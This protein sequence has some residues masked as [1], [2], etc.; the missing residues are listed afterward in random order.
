MK[1]IVAVLFVATLSVFGS[2]VF[3]PGHAFACDTL[4]KVTVD[5]ITYDR[6]RSTLEPCAVVLPATAQ[7]IP[8]V[9]SKPGLV[10]PATI[11]PFSED[12]D[13]LGGTATPNGTSNSSTGV[14]ATPSSPGVSATPSSLGVASQI[15]TC[16]DPQD[17]GQLSEA[18][19]SFIG[20]IGNR[21]G[22]TA[23]NSVLDGLNRSGT[24]GRVV[25]DVF[26]HG[27]SEAITN[28]GQAGTQYAGNYV[29]GQIQG[30]FGDSQLGQAAG[31]IV[32]NAAGQIVQ[33]V[34]Q[35]VVTN[36]AGQF[37]VGQSGGI[38][39]AISGVL[40]GNGGSGVLS[41]VLGGSGVG[42][43]TGILS[44]PV[45]D[46][47]V[48]GAVQEV[49]GAVQTA[50]QNITNKSEEIR[51][52]TNSLDEQSK[53]RLRQEC[54]SKPA[55]AQLVN[56]Q[57]QQ[58]TETT[59]SNTAPLVVT[60]YTQLKRDAS[61]SAA[62]QFINNISG[63]NGTRLKQE[64]TAQETQRNDP[65]QPNC[66]DGNTNPIMRM[67]LTAIHDESCTY[68]GQ[69][70]DSIG[71]IDVARQ[72]AVNQTSEVVAQGGG[73]RSAGTCEG[74]PDDPFEKCQGPNDHW[75]TALPSSFANNQALN[76]VNAPQQRL[77]NT[78][79]TGEIIN[80]AFNSLLDE[81][82]ATI[83]DEINGGISGLFSRTG[84]SGSRNNS[85]GSGTSG[86]VTNTPDTNS[87]SYFDQLN[88]TTLTPEDHSDILSENIA[89]A[90][91]IESAYRSTMETMAAN[92]QVVSDIYSNIYSCYKTLSTGSPTSI[93]RD[94]ALNRATTAST[95]VSSVFTAQIV[96]LDAR[97]QTSLITAS[98]LTILANQASATTDTSDLAA[99]ASA[100][101]TLV[102]AHKTHTRADL[103]A[104]VNDMNADA[105][106]LQ[107][108]AD[109][110]AT[111]QLTT[112]RAIH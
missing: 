103:Q 54:V 11:T 76:A 99:L 30:A 9:S 108:I 23:W 14:S 91:S 95:T 71:K 24:A 7:S 4:E 77:I 104:L 67:W 35:N 100:Y 60:D 93:T 78:H 37:G 101:Q 90:A 3:V 22:S 50:D 49:H 32:G 70:A 1:K 69:R 52:L 8:P 74:R 16:G 33:N 98:Q 10:L 61:Q 55:A 88:G 21:I 13:G 44:V 43:V 15:D 84:S 38:G 26:R 112:C 105:D 29:S 40:G 109:Q 48:K 59:L 36:I 45:N 12:I 20:D 68:S 39:G 47:G 92:L 73:L 2:I 106:A 111:P 56:L 89:T 66:G 97:I 58:N 79:E 62:E 65:V 85:S 110:D 28:I 83:G 102:D 72:S 17:G 5:G 6:V 64:L 34:G 19:S 18:F 41:G 81:V 53:I 57:L 75:I 27:A 107:V 87:G 31:R 94:E 63:R 46:S 42:A 51:V 80:D 82:F 96:S 86:G 25:S